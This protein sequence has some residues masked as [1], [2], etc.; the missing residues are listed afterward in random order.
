MWIRRHCVML[1]S[2]IQKVYNL[3]RWI[4][5]VEVNFTSISKWEA[6]VHP[7]RTYTGW[8]YYSIDIG[9]CWAVFEDSRIVRI[10]L[11]ILFRSVLLWLGYGDEKFVFIL[12]IK[13]PL[14]DWNE[15]PTN[16]RNLKPSIV[17]RFDIYRNFV[18]SRTMSVT[19]SF[20][21]ERKLSPVYR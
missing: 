5:R 9:C 20:V 16:S 12:K 1:F 2:T 11:E 18:A 6:R 3:L 19:L 21:W 13:R 10:N 15:M 8:N 4:S 7:V 17:F 14:R